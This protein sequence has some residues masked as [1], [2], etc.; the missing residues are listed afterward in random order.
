MAALLVNERFVPDRCYRRGSVRLDD[1]Y[2]TLGLADTEQWFHSGDPTR[3]HIHSVR[4]TEE[5]QGHGHG[6]RIMREAIDYAAALGYGTELAVSPT[7]ERAIG[8][9]LSLGFVDAPTPASLRGYPVGPRFMVREVL[10]NGH[11]RDCSPYCAITHCRCGDP[12]AHGERTCSR[13]RGPS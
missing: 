7:N 3:L 13:H 10:V 11:R 6:R 1:E 9:Y 12:A 5:H 4:V 8:L 2:G